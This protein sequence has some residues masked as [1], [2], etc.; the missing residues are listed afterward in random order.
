MGMKDV[1]VAPGTDHV[2]A[3]ERAGWSHV[4]TQGDHAILTKAG[5]RATLSVP[6]HRRE[7]R[8]GTIFHL[9]QAAG[10]TVDEYR[11]HFYK[12]KRP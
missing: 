4:R 10:M 12:G 11:R 8:R 7:A 9:I 2:K 3:F 5:E 6:L 1:P